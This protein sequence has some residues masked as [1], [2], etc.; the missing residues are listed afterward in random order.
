MIVFLK[1]FQLFLVIIVETIII[2]KIRPMITPLFLPRTASMPEIMNS[3]KKAKDNFRAHKE[4]S[5][6]IRYGRGV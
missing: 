2:D 5:N 1:L 4:P 3:M 6:R